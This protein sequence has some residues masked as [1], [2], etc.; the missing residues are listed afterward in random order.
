LAEIKALEVFSCT[1]II[2]LYTDKYA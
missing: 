2:S 1:R